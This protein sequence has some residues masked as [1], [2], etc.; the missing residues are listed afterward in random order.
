MSDKQMV[1]IIDDDGAMRNLLAD[2]LEAEGLQFAA[3]ASPDEFLGEKKPDCPSCLIVDTQLPGFSGVD[4]LK[5]IQSRTEL[6]MPVIVLSGSAT[7]ASAVESMKMGAYEFLEKPV[8]HGDLLASVREAIAIDAERHARRVLQDDAQTR[9]ALLTDRERQVLDL[10]CEG[11]S[12]KQMAMAL[13][14][15]VKTVAIHRWHL[16][17]KL[18]TASATEAV[19]LAL[20]AKGWT[21][22]SSIALSA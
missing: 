3:H 20:R 15:S 12:N 13:N 11:Q 2:E 10:I 1:H 16:M 21:N 18:R 17:T 7:V 9:L 6:S 4:V 19:H 22:S 14:I 8:D 5:M